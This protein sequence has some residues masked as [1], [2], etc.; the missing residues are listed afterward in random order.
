MAHFYRSWD[1]TLVLVGPVSW[2][3]AA[4]CVLVTSLLI[5]GPWIELTAAVYAFTL[6]VWLH[7]LLTAVLIGQV[8][9]RYFR[10]RPLGGWLHRGLVYYLGMPL[11]TLGILWM[12]VGP[13]G[14]AAVIRYVLRFPLLIGR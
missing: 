1:R 5:R 13:R 3:M 11:I 9:L 7:G 4:V 8:A 14:T 10:G 6:L 12:T 2:P